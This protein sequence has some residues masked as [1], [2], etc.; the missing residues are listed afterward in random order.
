VAR[1]VLKGRPEVLV[2]MRRAPQSVL[3]VGGALVLALCSACDTGGSSLH[4]GDDYR[5][6]KVTDVTGDG[7]CKIVTVQH[8]AEWDCSDEQEQA[9]SIYPGSSF[10]G[11]PQPG[12]PAASVALRA[13]DCE[14]LAALQR[15]VVKAAQLETLDLA[16]YGILSQKCLP[17]TSFQ[18]LEDGKEVSYCT[19]DYGGSTGSGGNFGTGGSASAGGPLP[20]APDSAED[21]SA[22]EGAEEYSTTN[23]Q[24]ADV[25]EADFVKNDSG[26][27]Y[28]LSSTGLHVVDAWPAPETHEIAHLELPGEPRRL[29]LDGDKLVVYLR[30]GL[31]QGP[32]YETGYQE[33]PSP[34]SQGC[35]YGYQ[36]RFTSEGGRTLVMVFDVSDPSEPK[37]LRRYEMSGGYVASR[38]VGT[39]V[40]TVVLDG[41]QRYLPDVDLTLTGD[42]PKEVDEN[43]EALKADAEEEVDSAPAAEFLPWIH[44]LDSEGSEPSRV[45]ACD[46]ALAAEAASGTSFVSV[47]GFDLATLGEPSRTLVAGKPGYVYASAE[48][49]YLATDGVDGSDFFYSATAETDRSTLHKFALNGIDSVYRGSV[50]IPG[51]VLNQFAMDELDGVLRV[52][53]SNG[54]VPDPGVSS[55]LVTISEQQDGLAVLGSIGNIAPT[56]DIRSVRFDGTR[57]FVVTFKKTDPLFVFDLTN[58]AAPA[59]LGELKIP[60]FSTYMHPLDEDHLLAIGFD[61]DDHG[62]F[63]Y[64]DGIQLQ[65]FDVSELSNPL[66]MHKTVIGTRGSASEALMNHLAFNYFPSKSLL[67]LPMTIC[68]GGDD[69]VYG[70]ELTFSG[71]MVFDVSLESG[72]TE[73]GRMP[74]V[75][76]SSVSGQ[77]CGTWWASSTSDVKRS[78]FMDDYAIGISD[79]LYQVASVEDL[80]GVLQSLP[81]VEN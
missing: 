56:E 78:I 50:S 52:A 34:S 69:G 32:G 71:L 6:G 20:S 55:N 25:D 38:R 44:R 12:V 61:A 53:T 64:F 31:P 67:A 17:K 41:T 70:D 24:V 15:P 49:L 23:N 5:G 81:L 68:E 63:A 48:A 66:L 46:S 40:Y 39:N 77:S 75:S 47:V 2:M 14:G 45:E 36:C 10:G 35:T 74:F 72:I 60:G 42:S 27:V 4:V 8:A 26:H 7:E 30:T 29:F 18:Y 11:Y 9:A 76:P 28:V 16:R 73:K 1:V 54:W 58:P 80:S 62:D 57:G 13:T 3:G 59:I 33:T 43:Y 51:H 22:D 37:E 19:P 79:S 21:P 65:I